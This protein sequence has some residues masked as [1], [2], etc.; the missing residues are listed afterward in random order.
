[1]RK[2]T[3]IAKCLLNS[4]M[5]SDEDAGERIVREYFPEA[6]PGQEFALWNCDLPDEVAKGIIKNVGCAMEIRVI[7]MIRE[8]A[9]I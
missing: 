1:M 9:K 3:V 8:L 4:S 2:S 5:I 6:L 7:L